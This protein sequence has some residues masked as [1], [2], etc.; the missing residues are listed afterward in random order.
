[1]Y[2]N[3]TYIHIYTCIR[4]MTRHVKKKKN[5]NQIDRYFPSFY[6]KA[7]DS[8]KA[9]LYI[10]HENIAEIASVTNLGYWFRLG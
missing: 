4:Y 8:Y 1:M 6:F 10:Y 2:G 9:F 3:G 5:Y 7:G